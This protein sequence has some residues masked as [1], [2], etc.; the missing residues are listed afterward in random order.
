M[1]NFSLMQ[2]L[3]EKKLFIVN[4][5][6]VLKIEQKLKVSFSTLPISINNNKA[7]QIYTTNQNHNKSYKLNTY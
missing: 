2:L 7:K 4:L 6:F 3:Y 1:S 5:Y